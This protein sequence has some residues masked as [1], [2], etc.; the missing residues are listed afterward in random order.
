[1]ATVHEQTVRR[2]KDGDSAAFAELY[3]AYADDL[4][5]FALYYLGNSADAEDAVQSALLTAYRSL[6]SLKKNAAFRSWLFKILSNQCRD[7]LRA[8]TRSYKIVPLEDADGADPASLDAF[9]D[10]VLSL[11]A[12]L[13]ETERSVLLLSVLGSYTGDEIAGMLGLRPGT[14]RACKSR[15][16]AKLRRDLS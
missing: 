5:H 13:S 12:P 14:V 11:L 16:L 15:A 1:M 7:C 8:R 2:A 6:P 4:Y 3:A 10:D 9:D